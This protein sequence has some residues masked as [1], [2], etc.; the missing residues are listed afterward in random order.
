MSALLAIVRDAT[1]L[2]VEA[3]AAWLDAMRRART[4]HTLEEVGEAA[5]LTKAGVRYALDPDRKTTTKER[6]TR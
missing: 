3:R 4:K 5:G 2:K 1:D 6:S